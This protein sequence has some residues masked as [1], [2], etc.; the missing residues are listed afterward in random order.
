VAGAD[1]TSTLSESLLCII[2]IELI[3]D[4]LVAELILKGLLLI[5]VHLV[6]GHGLFLLIFNLILLQ[7]FL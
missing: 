2:F 1:L 7:R 6:L 3:H 4:I 5:P